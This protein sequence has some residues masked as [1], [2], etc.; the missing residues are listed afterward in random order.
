MTPANFSQ[1][2]KRP[3]LV[4]KEACTSV[5]KSANFS[6]GHRR[7]RKCHEGREGREAA[8]GGAKMYS[9]GRQWKTPTGALRHGGAWLVG[10]YVL[11]I[12]P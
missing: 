1:C 11:S 8:G 4:S 3:M 9:T 12:V 10:R 7:A 5:V 2:P 6:Q